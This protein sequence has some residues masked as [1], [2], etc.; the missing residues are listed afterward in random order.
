VTRVGV[1]PILKKGGVMACKH[2]RTSI[3]DTPQIGGPTESNVV[4][5]CALKMGSR[6]KLVEVYQTLFELGHERS[7]ITTCCP[8]AAAEEWS[9]CPYFET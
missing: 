4:V 5:H 9:S 6:Q 3:I 1:N 7:M 2:A 8:L